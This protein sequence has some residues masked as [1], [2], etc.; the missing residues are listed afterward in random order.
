MKKFIQLFIFVLI[1]FCAQAQD[2][3]FSQFFASPLT[4][5]P[6]FTG[7]FNGNW[8]LTAN[9]K[10]QW[11]GIDNAYQTTSAS[12]DLP[13]LKKSIPENDVLGV[14]ISGL[15]DASAA[16]ALKLN[17]GSISLSYHKAL[18]EDGYNTIGAG[19]QG[20]YASL[21]LDITKLTFEDELRQTGF[22][23]GTSGE[24]LGINPLTGKN[25][26]Y[27]DMNAGV[28]YSG[29]S[30]GEN[31]YYLGFSLYHINRPNVS[32]KNKDW[33]LTSRT[34]IH[35]GGSFPISDILDLNVSFIQQF[36]NKA[37]E[38]VLG[39]ALAILA[40]GDPENPTNLYLGSWMRLGD[41][42]IPY[43][44][45]EVGGLRVGASYDA[46]NSA[47]KTVSQLNKNSFEFSIIYT[48]KP[49]EVTGIPCPR[50]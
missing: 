23:Q 39:G 9:T 43:L 44:G 19:F 21:G 1:A 24:Y 18:D 36:Q 38:T 2:P 26:N 27:L 20:T 13:L 31:N 16:G 17:Y 3:H 22:Q 8:R 25:I 34:T 42:I 37:T 12:F 5:N 47:L 10:K 15:T 48:K 29:S 7:K 6:A 41:A 46:T 40:N 4:L 45:L 32:F 28:L 49:V 14:G 35:G 11:G 30:N 50:F 33:F